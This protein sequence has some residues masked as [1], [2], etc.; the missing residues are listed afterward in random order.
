MLRLSARSRRKAGCS[1]KTLPASGVIV[2]RATIAVKMTSHSSAVTSSQLWVM[3]LQGFLAYHADQCLRCLSGF[4]G[5][6]HHPWPAAWLPGAGWSAGRTT[7]R[8]WR[9]RP[10]RYGPWRSLTPFRVEVAVDNGRVGR[11][12][13]DAGLFRQ[14]PS[15]PARKSAVAW[16]RPVMISVTFAPSAVRRAAGTNLP[17]SRMSAR[18][19][20]RPLPGRP[21]AGAGSCGQQRCTVR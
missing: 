18:L 4:L 2:T 3:P 6:L 14:S 8:I 10:R 13:D 15:S 17:M 11:G 21:R 1:S 5:E 19:I 7:G 9:R 16:L 12:A 20:G